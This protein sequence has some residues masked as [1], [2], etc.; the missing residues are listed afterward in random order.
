MSSTKTKAEVR[1]ESAA[2]SSEDVKAGVAA[3]DGVNP[4]RHGR[5]PADTTD[6][7]ACGCGKSLAGLYST[8]IYFNDRCKSVAYE[9]DQPKVETAK[10]TTGPSKCKGREHVFDFGAELCRCGGMV[11]NGSVRGMQKAGAR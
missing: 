4:W 6:V 10:F 9:A 1:S 7:C 11:S 3:R 8:R 2:G 5:R